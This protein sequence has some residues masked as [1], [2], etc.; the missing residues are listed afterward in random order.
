ME[1]GKLVAFARAQ[2]ARSW[3]SVSFDAIN[4]GVG[5]PL[6]SPMWWTRALCG[7]SGFADER[8]RTR[9]AADPKPRRV[10]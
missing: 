6:R 8:Q 9:E 2:S 1:Q 4:R 7:C 10:A 5:A 3:M